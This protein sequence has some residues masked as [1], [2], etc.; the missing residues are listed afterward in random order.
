MQPQESRDG[1][2][3]EKFVIP[4]LKFGFLGGKQIDKTSFLTVMR[5]ASARRC[6]KAVPHIPSLVPSPNGNSPKRRM[7]LKAESSNSCKAIWTCLSPPRSDGPNIVTLLLCERHGVETR[8]LP[9]PSITILI[10]KHQ[11]HE[12]LALS[13]KPPT[14]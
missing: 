11:S 7:N 2:F 1:P 4:S 3:V 8:S 5:K 10:S 14:F 12:I 9:T 13:V 6:Q